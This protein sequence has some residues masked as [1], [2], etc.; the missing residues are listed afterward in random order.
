VSGSTAGWPSELT[1]GELQYSFDELPV[2]EAPG[3][4]WAHHGIALLS[5]S[6]IVVCA[7]DRACLVLLEPSGRPRARIDTDLVEMHG[8]RLTGPP[9]RPLLFV[10]DNGHKFTPARPDYGER[11]RPGRVVALGLDGRC[12][13]ELS[14]PAIAAYEQRSWQPCAVAVDE[15]HLGGSGD[16]FVA[17]GYGESLLHRFAGDGTWRATEDGGDSGVAFDTPHDVIIDRRR[18]R[19]EL[20][21]ADRTNRRLVAFDLNGQF[22]R[23]VGDGQLTSPSALAISGDLLFVAELHGRVVA[24]DADDNIQGDLGARDDHHRPGWPNAVDPDGNT[25]AYRDRDH[26]HFNSPHGLATDGTGALYVTEWR[27][28]GRLVRLAPRPA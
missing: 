8:L 17:D 5:D 27:I 3:A 20:L 9:D 22:L 10:A 23:T 21:V 18:P 13:L 24:I 19:P 6:T 2:D 4:G 7:P 26:S 14:V 28:G 1:L 12:E 25:V 16:V 15:E 11:R